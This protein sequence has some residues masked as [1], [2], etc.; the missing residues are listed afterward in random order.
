MKVLILPSIDGPEWTHVVLFPN[1]WTQK[2][3]HRKAERAIA[4][5]QKAGGFEWNWTSIEEALIKQGFTLTKWEH[6]P[7]WDNNFYDL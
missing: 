2:T 6:G 3:A 5:G 7:F 1:E 4:A